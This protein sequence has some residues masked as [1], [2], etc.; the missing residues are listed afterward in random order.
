MAN[1]KILAFVLAGALGLSG[2]APLLEAQAV[3]IA[4]VTGRVADDQG[5]SVAG[6]QL[7]MTGIETGS[8]ATAVSNA[9]GIYSFPSLAIGA[10]RMESTFPGFQTYVENGIVLRVGDQVQINVTMKVGN[11]TE[12]VEVTAN[13]ALVQT[14]QSS[15]SQVVDQQR[16]VDLPLNG[17]DPTQLITISGASINHSDGTNT[18]SKSFFS[19]QSISIAGSAGNETNYLLDGGDNNDSFTNVNMP[20]PFPDALQEFS[21][22]TSTLPAR[23]GL[24]PGGVVNAVTKSGTNRLHGSLFEFIRNGNANAINY[25]APRQDS[26][27][28][29]Q[30]GGTIGGRILKDRLF[31]FGGFQQSDIRQD[32]SSS[33]AFVPTA[34]A[35]TGD[36]SGLDGAGCQAKGVA[37]TI[38]DPA[39]GTP[40]P[41][42][43]VAVSRFDPASV[44]LAKYLPKNTDAC[45]K[46]YFGIPVQSDESQYVTRVDWV[47]NSKQTLYGRYFADKYHLAAFFD[48]H[49]ILVTAVAGNEELAQTFVLGHTYTVNSSTVNSFHFTVGRRTDFRGPNADGV[50]TASLGISNLYQGTKNFMQIAVSN[51]GFAVG[52]GTCALGSFN[53]TSFQE[54]DDVDIIR[55]KHQIALG[56]DVLRTRDTQ[57][58]HYQ[59]NGVFNFSG[60][61]TNDPLLDFLMG[62]MNSFSQ[63]GPQLNDLRQTVIGAYVQD[64]FHATSR[65]VVNFGVRWEPMLPEYDHFNRGSTFSRAAFDANRP[66]QVYVNA[67]VGSLFYGD[68][69]IPNSF[70]AKRLNDYS[71]RLGIVYNPDGKGH[72]TFRSGV[73]LLY[74]SV[75]TFIPYRMVAQNPP[76]GPQVTNTNGPYQFSNPWGTVPGGNPFPLPAPGKNVAF[77]PANAEV[78]LPPNIHPPNVIHWNAALQHRLSDN[79]VLS[80]TYLGNKT[81]HLWIG[82]ETNPAV[83]IP[84]TCAGKPCSSTGNTQ[85]RRVLSLA[86]PTA[87]QYYSTM[88][89][90][91]DGISANYNGLLTSVEHRFSH[92]YTVLANYTWSKCLGIAPV[93]S[94]GGG[95]VQDPNNVRGDYG[96]CS[97]D[98]K[99]L[100]NLSAVYV[101]QFNRGGRIVS[102]LLS[103]WN[104]APLVRYQSGLAVNPVSGKDN[105][106]TGVGN[107]R[108]NVVSANAYTGLPHGKLYQFINPGLFVQNGTGVFGNAGHNSLRGPGYFDVDL[109]LSREFKLRERLTLH[110]RA[111]SFNTLNHPNFNSPVANISSANFGQITSASDPRILQGSMKVTF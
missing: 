19:S 17:R 73:G 103:H 14:Q 72:T 107:D 40:F 78:F 5:A 56:V 89:V 55:G 82:N 62:R 97:Y 8:T 84:G 27:K 16:I 69:G 23:N 22:E 13:A 45:G 36:F 20:F 80:M 74:D 41:G 99:Q 12:R 33:T 30:F 52:C 1:R 9:D 75:A 105:S 70:T 47:I 46:T 98:A 37:R 43:Q 48:P 2:L 39:T 21:V 24:H 6:A 83:Y 76:F 42:Q 91:D 63:S 65:L 25:F 102:A 61:Y 81:S 85:A 7:K 106:L 32:P 28:R 101:S 88:V 57:N 26:L 79:W 58:N 51:G 68:P 4:S 3:S 59:D 34:A 100:F 95:V 31:Y 94:L 67:P 90:A 38:L 50:N 44:A 86:N 15:I 108:P 35:L 92:N 66:S 29:N 93:T 111:E 53:I 110:V 87:G 49:D 104:L 109:A 71:P 60:I 77:P 64:T 10:Y 11:V 54:A 18:G 96:P